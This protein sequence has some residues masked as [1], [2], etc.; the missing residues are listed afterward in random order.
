MLTPAAFEKLLASLHEDRQ[1][2]GE[3]YERLRVTLMRF[4]EWRGCIAPDAAADETFDRVARRLDEG[5]PVRN[6]PAY[7][8]RVAAFVLSEERHRPRHVPLE[9]AHVP[10]DALED[11]RQREAQDMVDL[12]DAE[13]LDYQRRCLSLLPAADRTFIVEYHRG[14]GAERIRR[15]RALAEQLGIRM[16]AERIRAH[17]IRVWLVDC[18]KRHLSDRGRAVAGLK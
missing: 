3:R 7:M 2:A 14:R 12:L 4:L 10:I 6:V 9:A 18:A 15:R 11:P 5:I 17:R 1:R 13:L 8:L 16:N